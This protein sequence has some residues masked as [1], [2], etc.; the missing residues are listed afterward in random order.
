M[1]PEKMPP[2]TLKTLHFH[3]HSFLKYNAKAIELTK[4]RIW[5]MEMSFT[6][7]TYECVPIKKHIIIKTRIIYDHL[8]LLHTY[9]HTHNMNVY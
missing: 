4:W 6:Y 9:M 1:M 7:K 5:K 3:L 8:H 2:R